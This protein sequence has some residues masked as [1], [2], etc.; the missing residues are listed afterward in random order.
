MS[1][2]R[3]VLA[4]LMVAALAISIF[5]VAG[6]NTKKDTTTTEEARVIKT[7]DDL[8]KGDKVGVQSGTSG[9]QWATDNLKP[10]GIEV[11]PYD[12][13]LGAFNALQAGDVVAVINDL[14]VSEDVAK[15]KARGIEVVQTIKTNEDYAF[16]LNQDNTALRDALNWGLAEVVKSGEYSTLYKKWFKVE[17]VKLPEPAKSTT[18]P[19]EIKTLTPGKIIVGSDTTYPPFENVEDGVA[20]GF[21]VDL[22]TAIGKQLGLEVEFKTYK[23]D[24]LVTGMQAG[25]EFDM[26]ASAMTATGDKGK[27]R[28]KAI[29]FTDTYYF[30]DQSLT[31][32]KAAE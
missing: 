26:V 11:V 12:D 27:E 16:G 15:D 13:V 32:Q 6:C 31:V 18:K 22:V 2:F 10:K 21:D 30:S 20:V 24:A 5:A 9:E 4:L 28:R 25:T 1:K 3:K 14:P 7:T 17:P 29:D 19:A 8:K 23:F